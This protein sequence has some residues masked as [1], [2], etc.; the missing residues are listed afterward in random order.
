[1]PAKS[2]QATKITIDKKKSSKQDVAGPDLVKD[3]GKWAGSGKK[4][5]ENGKGPEVAAQKQ[6]QTG[7]GELRT[8][9]RKTKSK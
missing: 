6:S 4:V 7:R 8:T 5:V 2:N 1:M 3:G 9:L